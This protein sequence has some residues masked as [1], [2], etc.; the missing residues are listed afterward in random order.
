MKAM[1][2]LMPLMLLAA[3]ASGFEGVRE[4]RAI[5]EGTLPEY[6]Q[7]LLV[8]AVQANPQSASIVAVLGLAMP[9]LA[10]VAN[11]TANPIDNALLIALNKLMQTV[12]INP[13][14]NQ[15]DVLSWK[16][17]LTNKPKHWPALL[18]SKMS[19]A[20]Q[21]LMINSLNINV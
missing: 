6:L 8:A 1:I 14:T 7:S 17:M 4:T 10:W 21:D 12:V 18:R 5:L 19:Q 13:A 15:P 11:R 16:D 20:S 9:L 3:C 2:V